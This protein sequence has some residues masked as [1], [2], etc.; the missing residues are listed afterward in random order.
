MLLTLTKRVRQD[1]K[2]RGSVW[3]GC[4]QT[5]IDKT[6]IYVGSIVRYS[7]AWEDPAETIAQTILHE[8][9]HRHL[10]LHGI[11]MT[12]VEEETLCDTYERLAYDPR[13][14]IN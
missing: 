13:P 9:A 8:S 10:W 2:D 11:K 7:R 1:P 6:I 12:A 3:L 14:S 5:V 4:F